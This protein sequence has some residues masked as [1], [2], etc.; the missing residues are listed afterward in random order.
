[1]E[2]QH[3]KDLINYLIISFDV[4]NVNWAFQMKLA[5]A[6]LSKY[7]FNEIKYALDYYKDKGEKLT[8]L[9]FLSYKNNMKDPVSL[10]HA[11][12][13][14]RGDNSGDRNWNRIKQNSKTYNGEKSAEYLFAK[15]DEDN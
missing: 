14:S 2:N 11:E 12:M 3:K 10:Y 8:S 4:K 13:H 1:M 6:L 5:N 9:G 7:N 15:P